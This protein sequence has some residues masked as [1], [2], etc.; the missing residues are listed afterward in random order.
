MNRTIEPKRLYDELTYSDYSEHPIW[1]FAADDGDEVMFVDYPGHLIASDGGN[2]LWVRCEFKLND[3][4]QVPGVIG[5]RSTN[6]SI[7]LLEF[8][9]PDG[10]LFTFPVNSPLAGTVTLRQLAERF[11]KSEDV[12]FPIIYET[13]FQFK[14][15]EPVIGVLQW[16]NTKK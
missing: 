9:Q 13:P 6:W 3:G 5:F 16:M 7:Y 10:N 14:N 4:S 15:G 11:G 2:A 12:I 1:G 8:L